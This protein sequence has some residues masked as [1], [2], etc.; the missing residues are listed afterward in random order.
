MS[1][2]AVKKGSLSRTQPVNTLH[3]LKAVAGDTLSQIIHLLSAKLAS[4]NGG[5]R[6]AGLKIQ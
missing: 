5:R 6:R 1:L 2:R 4:P 3:M